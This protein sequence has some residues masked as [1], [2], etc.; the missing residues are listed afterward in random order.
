M[1]KSAIVTGGSRGIGLGI[2]RQ[3]AK[4]GYSITILDVNTRE[5]YKET[6]DQ[7]TAEGV[8]YIYIQGSITEKADRERCIDETEKNMVQ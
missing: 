1:K 4:D 6:L 8:D 3:L 7:L 2:V 5:Q